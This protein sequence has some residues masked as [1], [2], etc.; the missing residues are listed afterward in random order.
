MLTNLCRVVLASHGHGAKAI[1]QYRQ[2]LAS[3]PELVPALNNLAWVLAADGEAT[4][5]N[6]AEAVRLAERACALTDHQIPV[7]VGTLAAAYAEAGR[8]K[9]AIETAQQAR[10]LAQAAGQPEVD[11][12]NRQ[13]LGL[14]QSGQAY[15]E[16]PT[17][18]NTATKGGSK[19]KGGDGRTE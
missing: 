13:L 15:H 9:E 2:A 11:E 18:A 4:N 1:N 6:G 16:R 3:V 5:R 8:F 12:R 10:A 19:N 14:Y 7:L 17:P